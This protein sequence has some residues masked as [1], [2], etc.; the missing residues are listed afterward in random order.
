MTFRS[1]KNKF[2][3]PMFYKGD[4]LIYQNAGLAV[5]YNY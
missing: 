2:N 3:E 5:A 1:V 4:G